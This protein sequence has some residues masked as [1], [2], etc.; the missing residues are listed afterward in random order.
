M[1][2]SGSMVD[3]LM[4]GLQVLLG[5]L[6]AVA[7]KGPVHQLIPP[8]AAAICA[9]PVWVVRP[10][11]KTG[12]V[13]RASISAECLIAPDLGGDFETLRSFSIRQIREQATIERGPI[14]RTF[15]GLPSKYLDVTA[16]IKGKNGVT[17]RQDVNLATDGSDRFISSTVSR[18]I[19][20]TGYGAYLRKMDSRIDVYKTSIPTEDRVVMTAY[21][22]M[23]KPW[24]APEGMFLDELNQRV[25][26]EFAKLRDRVAL[27]MS[28]N[29]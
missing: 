27:E 17:I 1:V 19:S 22:E 6:P 21:S 4:I 2:A 28:Q 3:T 24:Y 14:D 29:Y 5:G 25:P 12:A 26:T 23:E 9:E 18:R 20:G 11:R 15:E 16:V 13:Y 7:P 10:Q 8:Y